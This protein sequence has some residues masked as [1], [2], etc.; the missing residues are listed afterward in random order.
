MS[1][2]EERPH[3]DEAL[4]RRLIAAQFP[5][6][7]ALP[8]TRVLP[9]GIDNRTFRLGS[10]LSVRLPSATGY[11][12]QAAKEQRWL[13]R[14]APRLPLPVPEPVGA[15]VP[16]EGF[17]FGWSV[18]RWLEGRAARAE[19]IADPVEFAQSLAGFLRAL[20]DFDPAGGP[21]PAQHTGFRGGPLTVY[22]AETRAALEALA[23]TGE[24]PVATASAIWETAL[25][26]PW[27]GPPVWFHGDIA[28][29]NLLV[30]GDGRL[31]AVIDFGC[32][33]VGDPACDAVIAW[34]LFTGES[35][36][37]FRAALGVDDATWARARGWALWKALIVLVPRLG[38]EDDPEAAAV[39]ADSRRVLNEI[40]SEYA[41]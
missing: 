4:V 6:W 39:A 29:G 18:N 37:V 13:P 23:G 25:A 15:G 14:L 28:W 26:A 11:A 35:R 34:T 9:G 33:G 8:V 1:E 36:R 22:D 3:I 38:R 27:A 17:P 32:T 10:E 31:S 21:A 41:G 40:F 2:P 12:G 30:D 19:R 16:G 24:V 5:R 7:S 20:Q